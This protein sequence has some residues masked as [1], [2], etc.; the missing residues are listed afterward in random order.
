MYRKMFKGNLLFVVVFIII[1]IF[2]TVKANAMEEECF[3]VLYHEQYGDVVY[4]VRTGVQYW[5]SDAR[6]NEGTLTLLV[7]ENGK[8]LVYTG[9]QQ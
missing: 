7:D 1:A 3:K 6:Y 4:D 2:F 5:R 9:E 8:P